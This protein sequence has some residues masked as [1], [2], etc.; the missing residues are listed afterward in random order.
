VARI[1]TR[2]FAAWLLCV[3][4]CRVFSVHSSTFLKKP[5]LLGRVLVH[6]S[7]FAA[8]ALCLF[9]CLFPWLF[10]CLFG[11]LQYEYE[12]RLLNL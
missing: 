7:L 11:S 5:Y 2:L 3:F 4:F 6:T 9:P 12:Y 8:A 1:G 10:L